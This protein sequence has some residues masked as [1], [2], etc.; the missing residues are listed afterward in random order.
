[1]NLVKDHDRTELERLK[2]RLECERAARIE[3]ES[4]AEE[5]ISNLYKKQIEINLLRSVASTAN[6]SSTIHESLRICLEQICAYLGWPVGHVYLLSE[7][8][9]D[10]LVPARIWHLK[11]P[12]RFDT[13]RNVTETTT[14]KSGSFGG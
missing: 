3:S 6:Q 12:A 14:F 11:D 1:M 5:A 4:I 2:R 8:S 13:F 7:K 10:E 9:K